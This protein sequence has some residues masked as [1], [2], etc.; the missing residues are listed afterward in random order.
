MKLNHVLVRTTDLSAMS[1]F[2]IEVIRLEQ[3]HRPPFPFRGAWFYSSGQPLVHVVEDQ[4]TDANAGSIAHVALEGANYNLLIAALKQH[5][6]SY[7]EKDVPL[8]GERQVFVS[9]P[10]GLMVEMLFPLGATN[11]ESH[12]YA[13]ELA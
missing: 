13:G 10:D 6:G 12:P 11:N 9:G 8:S 5:G 3:G 2:W 4:S 7:G 1:R